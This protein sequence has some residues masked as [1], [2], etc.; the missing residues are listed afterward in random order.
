MDVRVSSEADYVDKDLN[1]RAERPKT[2]QYAQTKD[3]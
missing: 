2:Q 3:F 1:Y